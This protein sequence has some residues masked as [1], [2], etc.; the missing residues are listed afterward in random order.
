MASKLT[1]ANSPVPAYQS[2]VISKTLRD[3]TT[4]HKNKINE[5]IDDLAAVAIGTTNAETTAARPYNTNLKERLDQILDGYYIINSGGVVSINAGDSQKVDVTAGTGTV[6]GI[7][8]N[9]SAAT[10]G[11]ISYTSANTRYDIV[12]INTDNSLTVVTGSEAASPV[13][14]TIASTQRA[15][16]V[17]LIGTASVALAWD[18]R[19]QGCWYNNGGHLEYKFEIQD[20]IDALSSGGNIFVGRG[21]YLESLTYDDNQIIVFEA[22]TVL[23][24]TSGTVVNLQTVDLSGKTNSKIIWDNGENHSDSN[25]NVGN[26]DFK[27]MTIDQWIQIGSDT[28]IGAI[29]DASITALTNKR[30]AYIDP[31]NDDLRT[32]EFDGNGWTQIGN[33]LNIATVGGPSITALSSTRIAFIDTSNEDLRTYDFDGTDWSQTGNDLN[34]S[35]LGEISIAALTSSRIAFIDGTHDDLRTYDFDGT[36]WSQTGND[37]NIS[38]VT[39]PAITALSSTRVAFIDTNNKDLRTYDFDGTDWSQTGNDLNI[40]GIGV[41]VD[42]TALTDTKIVLIDEGN[43]DLRT[44]DFDGTDWTQEV[45]EFNISDY[46]AFSNVSITSLSNTR[47]AYIDS[48]NDD[49]RVYGGILQMSIPTPSPAL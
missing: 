38:G 49:L 40:S 21:T 2:D 25:Y 35:G 15:L 24:D 9:W 27:N 7:E 41:T 34:I 44:Y 6:D 36:D 39:E 23:K 19:D 10:S 8:V 1:S 13:L 14:P 42:I 47:V 32:Y 48:Q 28:N 5:I 12:V 29:S 16:W 18:A 43:K 37:L 33:D 11:T 26:I 46:A 20:A 22:S 31:D 3:A 4:N 45:I 17:L 30:I